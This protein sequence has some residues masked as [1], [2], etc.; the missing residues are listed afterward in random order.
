[1][2]DVI[3]Y[4]AG[5]IAVAVAA[6][7][8]GVAAAGGWNGTGKQLRD[9][10]DARTS[11]S[12]SVEEF[13]RRQAALHA[14]LQDA[15]SIA[16]LRWLFL[17]ITLTVALAA[18][19][20]HATLGSST[21]KSV[22]GLPAMPV[23]LPVIAKPQESTAIAARP[24]GD[25]PSMTKRLADRLKREPGDGQGWALLARAYAEMGQFGDA[26]NAFGKAS[27]LLPADASLLADWANVHVK[28]GNGQW[29]QQA[30]DLV[31]RALAADS[32]N[33]KVLSLAGTEALQ[34]GDYNQATG[35]WTRA[36]SAA[37]P[38]SAEAQEADDALH[39]IQ[40]RFAGKPGANE[41]GQER[42][43]DAIRRFR[44]K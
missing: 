16:V 13:E 5:F 2:T 4:T 22:N 44:N 14:E 42:I 26:E 19:G 28:A 8:S 37:P 21:T 32:N 31:K 17:L 25:L 23:P 6:F 12:L 36:K 10:L 39:T 30:R 3:I 24:G 11:G 9:L 1:M 38:G 41:P 27:S 34:R 43:E 35:Y 7:G 29:D 33:P 15:P 18:A 20:L 40:N